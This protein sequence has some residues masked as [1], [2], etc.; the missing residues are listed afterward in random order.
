MRC[1]GGGE[2]RVRYSEGDG[3]CHC[4]PDRSGDSLAVLG[5][6]WFATSCH[7][8]SCRSAGLDDKGKVG[9]RLDG[10]VCVR[11]GLR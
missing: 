4:V 8:R 10:S 5:V 9:C 2:G 1:V 6:K 3:V 11:P 7:G